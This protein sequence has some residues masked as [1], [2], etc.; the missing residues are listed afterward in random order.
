MNGKKWKIVNRC[1]AGIDKGSTALRKYTR[2]IYGTSPILVFET[3]FEESVENRIRDNWMY[4]Y[5]YVFFIG[6][7]VGL[8]ECSLA[9]EIF[10]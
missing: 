4:F 1:Y 8:Y 2:Y 5:R 3:Y 10:F 9:Y 6:T 7:R